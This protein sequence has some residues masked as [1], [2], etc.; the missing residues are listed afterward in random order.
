MTETFQTFDPVDKRKGTLQSFLTKP[1]EISFKKNV[2]S[3]IEGLKQAIGYFS[4]V[5]ISFYLTYQFRT[6]LLLFYMFRILNGYLLMFLFHG[7]HE[8]I[9]ETPFYSKSLNKLFAFVFGFLCFRPCNHYKYYH[10]AHHKHT[11]NPKMDPE[12]QNT[13][14]DLNIKDSI[15][16]YIVYTLGFAFWIDRI[17]TIIRHALYYIITNL[18][19]SIISVKTRKLRKFLEISYNF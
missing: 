4:C 18:L 6:M 3:D 9:H 1:Q 12:L 15:V 10:W 13:F 5:F 14:L 19:S 8:C 11:G 17:S 2:R 7:L 16:N